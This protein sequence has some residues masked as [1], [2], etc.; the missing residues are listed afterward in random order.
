MNVSG[1]HPLF[2][3]G[4][5]YFVSFTDDATRVRW[6]SFLKV[7]SDV[8]AAVREFQAREENQTGRKIK[9]WRTDNG[10]EFVN[11]TMGKIAKNSGIVHETTAP[12]N[13]DQ[14]GTAERGMLP[15]S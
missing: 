15:V 13:P 14:N 4:E 1:P 11:N 12:Y 7:K 5:R 3:R 2:S 9:R 8:S 6:V 10:G